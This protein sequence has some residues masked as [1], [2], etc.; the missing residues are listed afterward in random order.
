MSA[1]SPRPTSDCTI[2]LLDT[3][4]RIVGWPSI[5]RARD[6]REKGHWHFSRFYSQNARAAGEPERD[7]LLASTGPVQVDG[8]RIREDGSQSWTHV[9]LSP[10]QDQAGRT[11]GFVLVL[12]TG[13]RATGDATSHVP[14]PAKF[15]RRKPMT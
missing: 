1:D 3:R 13:E 15:D 9:V 5:S 12:R 8:W 14:F 7:L 2:Y 4:G 10:F 6:E 11:L